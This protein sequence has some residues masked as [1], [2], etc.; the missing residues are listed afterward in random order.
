VQSISFGNLFSATGQALESKWVSTVLRAQKYVIV[1]RDE[2]K[3]FRT[4]YFTSEHQLCDARGE[5]INGLY[6]ARQ[7]E[8]NVNSV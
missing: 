7:S 4:Q 1:Q 6:L 5:F 2:L 8:D 3:L